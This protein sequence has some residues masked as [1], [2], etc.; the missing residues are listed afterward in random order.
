MHAVQVGGSQAACLLHSVDDTG[1]L[2]SRETAPCSCSAAGHSPCMHSSSHI[3]HEFRIF[4]C[5]CCVGALQVRTDSECERA[6]KEAALIKDKTVII[7]CIIDK[8]DCR[9]GSSRVYI[10]IYLCVCRWCVNLLQLTLCS[11]WQLGPRGGGVLSLGILGC[12]SGGSRFYDESPSQG[13]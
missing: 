13:R 3:V 7:E 1:R 11:R 4:K 10:V 9:C 8:D 2:L 6:V 12:F 5:K